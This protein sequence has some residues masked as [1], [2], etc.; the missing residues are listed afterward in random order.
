[1]GTGISKNVQKLFEICKN[2]TNEMNEFVD[3]LQTVIDNT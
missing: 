1:M 2:G 3:L